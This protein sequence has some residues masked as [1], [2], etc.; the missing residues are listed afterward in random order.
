MERKRM[1]EPITVPAMDQLE[2]R[3]LEA[4]AGR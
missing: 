4:R 2:P 1:G 3:R